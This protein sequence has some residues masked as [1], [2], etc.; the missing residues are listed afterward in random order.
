[1]M[2]MCTNEHGHHHHTTSIDDVDIPE[3]VLIKAGLE[4]TEK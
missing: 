1:M 2:W 4:F 3:A